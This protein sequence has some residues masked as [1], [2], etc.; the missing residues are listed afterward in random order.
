[1]TKL[2]INVGDSVKKDK[3]KVLK[4]GK[5]HLYRL[6]ILMSKWA[7]KVSKFEKKY[8]LTLKLFGNEIDRTE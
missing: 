1:M 5:L 2:R 3:E 4:K 8:S 6:E 7:E